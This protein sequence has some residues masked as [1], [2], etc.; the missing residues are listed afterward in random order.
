MGGVVFDSIGT[1]EP[2]IIAM[3]GLSVAG[4]ICVSLLR[5]NQVL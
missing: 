2:L 5:D 1:Y 3:V 4:L